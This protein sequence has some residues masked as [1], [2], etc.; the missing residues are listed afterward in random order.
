MTLSMPQSS[1]SS[2][3]NFGNSPAQLDLHRR[4]LRL[5]HTD[6]QHFL[7]AMGR[8]SG[9]DAWAEILS[10][11]FVAR[12]T[13]E[14]VAAAPLE[15]IQTYAR[16]I[17]DP[18]ERDGRGDYRSAFWQGYAQGFATR[19]EQ[20]GLPLSEFERRLHRDLSPA[21][22]AQHRFRDV[23]ALAALA[24]FKHANIGQQS[25]PQTM[26]TFADSLGGQRPAQQTDVRTRRLGM[27]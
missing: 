4:F 17:L 5:A 22:I 13:Q 11:A 23:C 19:S 3:N 24:D 15:K 7:N 12:A 9:Q 16:Y 26:Q 1:H 25:L 2:Q 20:A 6:G 18:A 10:P 21:Q 14:F 27:A 8:V